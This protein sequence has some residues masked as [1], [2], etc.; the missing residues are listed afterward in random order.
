M[1]RTKDQ[2]RTERI[3][4]V[5]E[6][7]FSDLMA[8]DPHAFRLKFRKMAADPFAFYRGSACLFFADQN[9]GD[10]PWNSKQTSRVWIHG[11]LHAENFGTYMNSDGV[12]VFDVNDFDEAYLGP[13]TWD[14]LRF[15]ASIGL[16]FR[17][18]AF[19]D[20]AIRALATRYLE[21]YA[22][23][24]AH[25]VD[26]DDDEDFALRLDNTHGAVHDALQTARASSRSRRLDS[27]TQVVD[28]HRRFSAKTGIRRLDAEEHFKV[29]QA[30]QEYLETVPEDRRRS[31]SHTG[32]YHVKDVVGRSGF[33]IGSAGLPAYNVLIEGHD[34]ALENDI[35]LSMKQGNVP[36]L[37][38]VRGDPKA[39]EYFHH[40]GHRT[41]VSQ[42]ALQVH[43][44]PLLGWCSIDGV[45]FVVDEL[46]PYEADL[47]WGDLT[48]PDEVGPVLDDLGRATAKT[49]CASDQDSDE[50]LITFQTEKAI[51]K[52]LSGRR[53]DLI[54]DLVERGMA[55]TDQARTDHELFVDVFRE[56]R[57]GGVSAT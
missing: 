12:L 43:A 7:A 8:A 29:M 17:A 34:Q 45:G 2:Q 24:V 30:F 52:V 31:H 47:D 4:N 57:I 26:G 10:D 42:R 20:E 50:S 40:E 39:D 37:S 19:P 55:Y 44:D 32:F 54:A 41:V 3:V 1:A 35:V 53:D 36:A 38:R 28:T 11:D 48:E 33:G 13:F 25:Y 5:L 22:D 9:S 46:S 18:K 16:M 49:H 56:N 15:V 6:D 14:L 51:A 27:M 21:A 23:Q